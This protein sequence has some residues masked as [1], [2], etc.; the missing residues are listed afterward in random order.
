MAILQKC[1]GT[2]SISFLGVIFNFYARFVSRKFTTYS[3]LHL[4]Q[5]CLLMRFIL[6]AVFER[7][8]RF[9]ITG[10]VVV[11]LLSHT[12][13]HGNNSS[14]VFQT[15]CEL[16]MFSYRYQYNSYIVFIFIKF[17]RGNKLFPSYQQKRFTILSICLSIC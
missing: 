8:V 3:C 2:F 14:K 5:K 6:S 17:C 13:L 12:I 4:C 9:L 1:L 16:E 10:D 11:E 15:S 7:T